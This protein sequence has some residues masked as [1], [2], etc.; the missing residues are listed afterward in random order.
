[1]TAPHKHNY[2]RKLMELVE[3]GKIPPGRL[4]DVQ[5]CHDDWCRI[6][7]GGYCN[8]DPEIKLIPPPE[9]FKCGG[10]VN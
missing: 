5:V 2:Y 9:R 8:C 6:Y 7:Q 1:M 4:T 10:G 3:Q